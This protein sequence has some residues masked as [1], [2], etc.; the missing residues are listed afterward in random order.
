MR[1]LLT[2]LPFVFAAGL[3]IASFGAA[4]QSPT[5]AGSWTQKAPMPAVRGEVAAAAV[6]N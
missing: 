2:R 4:A 1:H 6:D 5:P 3:I